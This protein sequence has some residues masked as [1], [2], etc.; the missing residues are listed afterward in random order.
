MNT[1]I[2][3]RA[4]CN[5]SNADNVDVIRVALVD[6][7]E[8]V[9][10]GLRQMLSSEKSIKIISEAHDEQEALEQLKD[11]SPDIIIVDIEVK[12]AEST[13]ITN[14]LKKIIGSLRKDGGE[15][16][17]IVLSDKRMLLRPAILSGATAYLSKNI[18]RSE[19]IAAIRVVHL[20]R[21]VLFNN[22]S[23]HFALV[24]L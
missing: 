18:C 11:K 2:F 19:L 3:H 8:A 15:V 23:S 21:A 10:E 16:S 12:D 1:G 13:D 5:E 20:W 24:K 14:S 4:K 9:R 6:S 7:R 17:V 22:S